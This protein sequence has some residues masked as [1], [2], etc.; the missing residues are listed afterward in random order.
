MT[1]M[2]ARRDTRSREDG[3]G[4]CVGLGRKADWDSETGKGAEDF[5]ARKRGER[6]GIY[7]GLSRTQNMSCSWLKYPSSSNTTILFRPPMWCCGHVFSDFSHD[8]PPP[9]QHPIALSVTP[10][11]LTK[12]GLGEPHAQICLEAATPSP[13]LPLLPF[14]RS[15]RFWPSL[16]TSPISAHSLVPS[17]RFMS[18]WNVN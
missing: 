3:A 15:S 11:A 2:T 10:S 16:F 9:M 7:L 13:S 18:L 1:V 4:P 12:D 14:P 8:A 6:G 5:D 17:S